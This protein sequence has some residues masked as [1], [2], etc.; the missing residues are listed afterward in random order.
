MLIH[1]DIGTFI[2]DSFAVYNF[3]LNTKNFMMSI[4]NYLAKIGIEKPSKLQMVTFFK[5]IG[6]KKVIALSR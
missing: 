5:Q 3:N 6:L 1:T 2:I 4:Y